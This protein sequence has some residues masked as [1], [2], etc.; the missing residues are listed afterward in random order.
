MAV[1][2]GTT[3]RYGN[4]GSD[5]GQTGKEGACQVHQRGQELGGVGVTVT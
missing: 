2:T 1:S 3:G 4:T 5:M